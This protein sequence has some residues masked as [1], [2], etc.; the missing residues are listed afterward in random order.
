MRQRYIL[1]EISTRAQNCFCAEELILRSVYIYHMKKITYKIV[2][3]YMKTLRVRK[4]EQH[5]CL[6]D[7]IGTD[8]VF[9][10][11]ENCT[12]LPSQVHHDRRQCTASPMRRLVL[13]TQARIQTKRLWRISS[14]TVLDTKSRT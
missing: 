13:Q 8:A 14:W 6:A 12:Q 5:A 2:K 9:F 7:I 3:T 11:A 1:C 10:S 4:L